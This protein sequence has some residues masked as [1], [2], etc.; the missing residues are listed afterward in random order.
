MHLVGQL[1]NPS[2]ALAAVF[3]AAAVVRPGPRDSRESIVVAPASRRL[4]NGVV[5]RAVVKVLATDGR[6]MRVAEIHLAVEQLL[7]HSVSKHSVS[8]SLAADARS[9]KARFERTT[10]GHYKIGR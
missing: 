7:G 2:T 4:G 6:P 10:R 1:S 9:K 5:Q 8:W 3:E